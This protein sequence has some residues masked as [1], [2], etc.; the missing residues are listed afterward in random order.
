MIATR[1]ESEIKALEQLGANTDWK[2]IRGPR[3]WED[4]SEFNALMDSIK[5]KAKK[6]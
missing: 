4:N 3:P 5:E 1:E 6:K 2:N